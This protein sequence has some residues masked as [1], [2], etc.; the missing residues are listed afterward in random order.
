VAVACY[1]ALEVLLGGDKVS[2]LLPLV[3]S[4]GCFGLLLGAVFAFDGKSDFRARDRPLWRVGVSAIAGL[5]LAVLWHWPAEGVGLSVLAA[6]MLGYF[7][8][9][10]A[11]YV[12]F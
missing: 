4:F 6:S 5:A 2:G 12:D 9:F 7:G 1:A 3:A 10:W 8:M 11:R